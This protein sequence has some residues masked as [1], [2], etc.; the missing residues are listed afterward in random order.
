M[1]GANQDPR[2]WALPPAAEALL[3][4]AG[5]VLLQREIPEAVNAAVAEAARGCGVPVFLD[6]G[7][8]DAPLLPR[9]LAAVTVLS[10]NETELSRLT[11]LPTDSPEAVEAAARALMEKGVPQVLVKL[12][13]D[14]S[15]LLAGTG[16]GVGSW[17]EEQQS[18][19][20]GG[21][22][23]PGE[24]HALAM[25]RVS[26]PAFSARCAAGPFAR[27]KCRCRPRPAP[28]RPQRRA[29]PPAVRARAPRHR[30]HR[31]RRLLHGGVRRGAPR[32]PAPAAR[33]AVCVRGRQ[34]VRAARGRDA[35]P[36]RQSGG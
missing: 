8:A 10:P 15:M 22:G 3:R 29:A 7:G 27:F 6:A 23:R 2:S 17:E 16:R 13:S 28:R 20:C 25:S 12:G 19:G 9:L 4:S 34:P 33:A 26:L 18:T 35:Q 24:L 11:G 14:G 32:G 21:R 5:A 1:G 30:H 31:R 36:A